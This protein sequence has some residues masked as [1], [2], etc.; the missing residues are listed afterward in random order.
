MFGNKFLFLSFFI[1]EWWQCWRWFRLWRYEQCYFVI[2]LFFWLQWTL[3]FNYLF[4]VIVR[5]KVVF[6][7]TVVGDWCF[8]YSTTDQSLQLSHFDNQSHHNKT[9]L[10]H[11]Y[12]NLTTTLNLT[13]KMTTAQVIE[14]S[15][16]NNSLSKDYLCLDDHAKQI[17]DSLGFKPFAT[18][19]FNV[20]G[21]HQHFP[22]SSIFT[23]FPHGKKFVSKKS[24]AHSTA[25]QWELTNINALP[26][27]QFCN[28]AQ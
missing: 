13:L 14:T 10:R 22:S 3:S 25:A 1:S 24:F 28:H 12:H 27:S 23:M 4:G 7:K 9:D 16:T 18:L 26:I 6:R 8:D 2:Y 21:L 17:T 11:K 19:S 5:V 20:G 15:V